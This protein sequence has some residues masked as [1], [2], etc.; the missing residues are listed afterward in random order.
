MNIPGN[1]YFSLFMLGEVFHPAYAIPLIDHATPTKMQTR[2][3]AGA[4]PKAQG[5]K[6][7]RDNR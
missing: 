7:K 4:A 1:L 6:I 5:E 3:T 2:R